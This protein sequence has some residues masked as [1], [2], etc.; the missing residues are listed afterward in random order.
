MWPAPVYPYI[1]D[2]M[3]LWLLSVSYCVSWSSYRVSS[4]LL[5]DIYTYIVYHIHTV[6]LD[7]RFW[8]K[9]QY[10][11]HNI[12]YKRCTSFWS[13]VLC[14]SHFKVDIRFRFIHLI[15]H[16]GHTFIIDDPTASV[17]LEDWCPRYAMIA[18][19]CI[20][21]YIYDDAAVK[22]TVLIHWCYAVRVHVGRKTIGRMPDTSS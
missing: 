18:C 16:K 17:Y 11:N 10:C 21:I 1:P 13:S 7:R 5:S 8:E 22:L 14:V 4:T 15:D 6:H 19:L 2:D 3:E 12:L 20:T 9:N